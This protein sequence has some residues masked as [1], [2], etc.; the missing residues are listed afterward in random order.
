MNDVILCPVFIMC[1]CAVGYLFFFTDVDVVFQ[2]QLGSSQAVLPFTC[3][4]FHVVQEVGRVNSLAD[5]C[6]QTQCSARLSCP[7]SCQQAKTSWQNTPTNLYS[8][9]RLILDGPLE[10][11]I[12]RGRPRM[13]WMTHINNC[14]LS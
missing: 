10:G 1:G 4:S 6:Q 14:Q 8:P 11:K 5:Y 13:K 12:T 9:T 2:I 7:C 3:E